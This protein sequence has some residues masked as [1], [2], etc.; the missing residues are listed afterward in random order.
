MIFLGLSYQSSSAGNVDVSPV[1]S[2]IPFHGGG[3]ESSVLIDTAVT[4][5]ILAICVE[6][7][8]VCSC[9]ID[10]NAVVTEAVG[11]VEIEDKHQSSSLEDNNLVT[12]ML[13]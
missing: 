2:A 10:S 13:Q 11:W 5:D 1:L 7:H 3:E 4:A 9:D 6:N 8:T 12:L